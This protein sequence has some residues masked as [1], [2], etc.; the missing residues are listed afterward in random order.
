AL[1]QGAPEAGEVRRPETLLP[2]AVQ[3]VDEAKL[4]RKPVGDLAG[5]VGRVVVDDEHAV[6]RPEHLAERA[7]HRLE[8]LLLVVGRQADDRA[9]GARVSLLRRR[10]SRPSATG[11]GLC[12][13]G[14]SINTETAA[15]RTP[16]AAPETKEP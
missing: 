16:G 11:G 2:R 14:G 6:V 10:K 12:P 13:P 4:R 3:D 9:H 5:A 1:R 8:V 15:A 7:E